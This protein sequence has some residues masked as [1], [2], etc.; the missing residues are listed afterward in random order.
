MPYTTWCY[1]IRGSQGRPVE[2]RTGFS[3]EK[4]AREQGERVKRM[5]DCIC[6]PNL[7]M[8]IVVTKE[9]VAIGSEDAHRSAFPS[10]KYP[11]QRLVFDAFLGS[12]PRE[13]PGRINIAERAIAARLCDS[14]P[15]EVDEHLALREALLALRRLLRE[16]GTEGRDEAEEIAERWF[17][18]TLFR[19]GSDGC[20]ES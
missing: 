16:M 20:G 9:S 4:E 6:F 5:I 18:T 1:E 12:N 19:N 2:I 7:E 14:I 8:L 10:V 13:L 11:W 17:T 15:P 3:S